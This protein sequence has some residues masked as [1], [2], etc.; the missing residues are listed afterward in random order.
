MIQRQYAAPDVESLFEK[1]V[2]LH[3]KEDLKAAR[4]IYWRILRIQPDHAS[5]LHMLGVLCYDQGNS[6][7]AVRF[8]R[9]AI[10]INPDCAEA[11]IHLGMILKEAGHILETLELFRQAININANMIKPFYELSLILVSQNLIDEASVSLRHIIEVN[12]DIPEVWHSLGLLY[13]RQN[14]IEKSVIALERAVALNPLY[15]HAL[16]NLALALLEQS[17]EDEAIAALQKAIALE[18]TYGDAHF[19]L[20]SV[21]RQKGKAQAA[22]TSFH[23]ALELA[24]DHLEYLN[25]IGLTYMDL[26]LLPEA[27]EILERLIA[28]R[29]QMPEAHYNLGLVC[30]RQQKFS[31]AKAAY[32]QAILLKPNNTAAY[33]NLGL[34]YD[35]LNRKK[36]ALACYQQV[37]AL[38]PEN[39][40]AKH[41]I[42]ALTQKKTKIAPKQYVVALFDQYSENFE[43][44]LVCNLEYSVPEK[45]KNILLT[46][47]GKNSLFH[48]ALDMG[49]GTGMCGKEFVAV[50]ERLTG[51]DLSEKMLEKARKKLVYDRLTRADVVDFL[52]HTTETF[53]LFISTDVFIYIG[54][55]EPVF[56]AV[57]KRAQQ[58]G[59]FIF[60]VESCNID[61][62]YVLRPSGRYAQSQTYIAELAETH[63]FAIEL[64]QATGIRKEE[65]RWIMGHV[66]ILKFINTRPFPLWQWTSGPIPL[67]VGAQ[68]T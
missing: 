46:H 32:K 43:H 2:K 51:V 67:R 17:R 68:L 35:L 53:D 55:L 65:G 22:L 52:T 44:D 34:I 25:E 62:D 13:F 4:E 26:G 30:Q 15:T 21:F 58:D 57:A 49:C 7:E 28:V 29:P 11:Y 33:N 18:P 5:T 6:D 47:L 56:K 10:E 3:E 42:A 36:E 37:A 59:Y 40:A 27:A 39:Q 41:L 50:A 61:K 60:S 9:K 38:D 20:A 54:E 23:R 63:G 14:K 19:L 8:I 64:C 24:P 45:L 12:S 31:E 48:N 66:Y 1:A 16:K